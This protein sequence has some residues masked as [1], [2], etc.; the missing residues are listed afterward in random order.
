MNIKKILLASLIASA[1][2]G[3][4][5][6]T[7][8]DMSIAGSIT[9]AGCDI[10]LTGGNIDYKEITLNEQPIFGTKLADMPVNFAITC[11]APSTVTFKIIDN[12]PNTSNATAEFGL[13]MSNDRKIGEYR[14]HSTASTLMLD[15]VAGPV[16]LLDSANG[17]NGWAPTVT[18]TSNNFYGV[19]SGVGVGTPV[20]F[21]SLSGEMMVQAVINPSSKLDLTKKIELDGSATMEIYY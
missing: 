4:F 18:I 6:A 20:A 19:K 3:A 12:K 9:P 2:A 17:N 5:A 1:S 14:F 10:V 7:S 11:A 13:G 21:T 16:Q 8:A 15:N